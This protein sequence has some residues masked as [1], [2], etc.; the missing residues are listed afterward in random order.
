MLYDH[1][2][3][4]SL[5]RAAAIIRAREVDAHLCYGIVRRVAAAGAADSSPYRICQVVVQPDG[6]VLCSY[7]KLHLCH[8]GDCSERSYFS[9]GDSLCTFE[10]RGVT[11]GLLICYDIRFPELC[12]Q[13]SWG[14]SGE[15]SP[16]VL[17][18]PAAPATV[19]ATHP[20]A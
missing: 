18:A 15:G 4:E 14:P 2:S 5:L 17:L 20:D 11:I 19:A 10:V 13:L 12:R 16:I 9:R 1:P 3:T 8:F 7:D 6:E